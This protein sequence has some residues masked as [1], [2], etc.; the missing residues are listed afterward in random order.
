MVGVSWLLVVPVVGIALFAGIEVSQGG[1]I[2]RVVMAG[3]GTVLLFASIVF[4]ELG[5]VLVAR[6]R[7][8]DVQ[9]VVVVLFGGYSEMDLEAAVPDDQVAVTVAG[10]IASVVLAGVLL[11]PAFVAPEAAGMRSILSL[12]AV[13][14]VGVAFFNLLPAYPLDGG[15]ILRALLVGAGVEPA[16][17]ERLTVRVGIGCGAVIVGGGVALSVAGRPASLMVVPVGVAVVVLAAG[18]RPRRDKSRPQAGVEKT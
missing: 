4:H 8:V 9:R 16:R 17:A 6:R 2:W 1:L 18:A 14:N 7:G 10:P 3:V 13:V 15:R 5:H 11:V 12:L